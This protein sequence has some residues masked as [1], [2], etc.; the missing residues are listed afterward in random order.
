[1][2]IIASLLLLSAPI[3]AQFTHTR[4]ISAQGSTGTTVSVTLGAAPATGSTVI[5]CV[6]TS[7]AVTA[8]TVKDGAG[9]PNN[10]TVSAGS[11]STF[12]SGAGQVWLAYLLNAPAT[13]N[14]TVTATWTTSVGGPQMWADVFAPTGGAPTFDKDAKTTTN[15]TAGTTINLPSITPTASGELLYGCAAAG[16][17]ISAPAANGT[18]SGWTGS[19]GAI[20][21]GDM[22]EYQLNSSA[23]PTTVAFTQ[24][25]GNWSAMSLAL[26]PAGGGGGSAISLGK[27][28]KLINLGMPN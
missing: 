22:A 2:R 21:G 8:L 14:A 5:V 4:G 24:S 15:P 10:Y 26:A 7:A 1:M 25:S 27:M 17:T 9:T 6:A 23:S 12:E 16:G 13:A 18:L 28:K 20:S 3:W 19:G 11:P